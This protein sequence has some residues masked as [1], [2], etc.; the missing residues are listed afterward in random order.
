LRNPFL[1]P[2]LHKLGL[3]LASW[4]VRA[5]DTRV[6]DA[7]KVARALI[8][9]LHAGAI[10]LLHDAHAARTDT[11]EPVILKVLPDVIEAALTAQLRFVTLRQASS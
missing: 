11:G 10:V 6:G 1:D 9:G 2:V 4:S 3:Q 5:F 8:Q 7:N